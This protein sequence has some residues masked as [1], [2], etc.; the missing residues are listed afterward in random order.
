MHIVLWV[1][2]YDCCIYVLSDIGNDPFCRSNMNSDT[3]NLHKSDI[4][5]MLSDLNM[6][7]GVTSTIYFCFYYSDNAFFVRHLVL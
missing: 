4:C 6:E 2:V 5:N 7:V 3:C 1:A